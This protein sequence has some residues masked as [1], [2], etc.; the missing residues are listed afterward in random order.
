M[1]RRWWWWCARRWR[2]ESMAA[3][4]DRGGLLRG[5]P[6]A[7]WLVLVCL[8]HM[9]VIL[10]GLRGQ[11]GPA[12]WLGVAGLAGSLVMAWISWR[13]RSAMERGLDNGA[14]VDVQ[15]LQHELERAQ[16]QRRASE[17]CLRE[18][19]DAV[20]AGVAIYD[21][22]DRLLAF[23]REVSNHYP[24]RSQESTIGETFETLMHR[25]LQA[26]RIAEAAGQEDAWLALRMAGR[27][28]IDTPLLRHT[29]DG[30]WVHFYEIRTPSGYLVM[31]RLDMT[32]MVEKGLAL[33][34]ANEKLLRLS[35]TDG[36]TGIAN[37]RMFDQTLQTEWQRSARNGS[38]LSL[39]MI[40]ID[41]FK[42]YNDYYGHQTGD[43]CLRQVARILVMC[44]KRSGELVAR[45]SGEEFAI[46]LPGTVVQ[47][48]KAIAQR[49]IEQMAEARIAH[50]DSPVSPWLTVSVGVAS[51]EVSHDELRSTLLLQADSALYCAK[52]AGR[53]RV[54][55]YDPEVVS[56][57]ASRP[58]PL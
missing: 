40:D 55:L 54:E 39:L 29:D 48:A 26:G 22:Q 53:A 25:E 31:T 11:A 12:P 36:L 57:L 44:A 46:V 5:V 9:A 7:A 24:Y 6:L 47:E 20:P 50:A 21:N 38:S 8:G 27:G 1:S 15:R 10:V 35:T 58:A 19:I 18:V 42:H 2:S 37:R 32:L 41:H 16:A 14:G 4:T 3:S 33:E 30:Q 56:A 45:Y 23:N 49:C 43:E 28:A 34:Q 17:V 51:M 52:R 13:S